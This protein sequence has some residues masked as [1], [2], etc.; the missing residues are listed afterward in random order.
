MARPRVGKRG[1][2][3]KQSA[4]STLK[5]T[6]EREE[7]CCKSVVDDNEDCN[8]NSGVGEDEED[9]PLDSVEISGES[10][11]QGTSLSSISDGLGDNQK[12]SVVQKS[13]LLNWV[14][15]FFS[16]HN[17]V[18]LL[19][20]LEGNLQLHLKICREINVPSDQWTKYKKDALLT[21]KSQITERM[22]SH[23]KSVHL[24]YKG[25]CHCCECVESCPLRISLH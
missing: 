10:S 13:N 12:M 7:E 17:K 4:S 22:S 6:S 23:R 14:D 15:E 21:I 1:P 2:T 24:L 11:A 9:A 5:R 3:R 19:S 8:Y 18:M 20:D 25:N 16:R